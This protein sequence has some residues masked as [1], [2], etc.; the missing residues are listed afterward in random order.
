MM[1]LLWKRTLS[2]TTWARVGAA[3]TALGE[4]VDGLCAPASVAWGCAAA[5][6]VRALAALAA[7]QGRGVAIAGGEEVG[8]VSLVSALGPVHRRRG[9]R[10]G[11]PASMERR[12]G[13]R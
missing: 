1:T 11:A 9:H 12:A 5:E 4:R 13:Y 7:P 10:W 8:A 6:T 2:I 3:A